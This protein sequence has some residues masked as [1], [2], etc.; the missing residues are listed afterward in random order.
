[1]H[2]ARQPAAKCTLHSE[3][4]LSGFSCRWLFVLGFLLCG[5]LL[6]PLSALAAITSITPVTWN[7]VGLDSNSPLSAQQVAERLCAE[8]IS[9]S[10]PWEDSMINCTVSVGVAVL[11]Q[12]NPDFE[13]LLLKADKSLYAAKAAGRNRIHGPV[14]NTR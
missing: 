7:V 11:D 10:I 5:I 12:Q 14:R 2:S 8:V 4:L 13:S 9:E 6:A 1:M 3:N